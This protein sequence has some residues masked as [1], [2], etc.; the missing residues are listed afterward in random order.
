MND[1]LVIVVVGILTGISGALIGSIGTDASWTNDCKTLQ[2]HRDGTNV[3]K[4]ELVK[5][6]SQ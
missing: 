5:K 3:Y 2:V 6:G 1:L 4:C